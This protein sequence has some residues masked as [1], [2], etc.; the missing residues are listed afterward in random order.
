[1]SKEKLEA[2]C[3]SIKREIESNTLS[4]VRDLWNYVEGFTNALK[5]LGVPQDS[6]NYIS[7]VSQEYLMKKF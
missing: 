4:S 1:M 5:Q 6:I 3:E 2:M 7:K